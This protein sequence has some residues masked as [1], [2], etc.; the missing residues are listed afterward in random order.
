MEKSRRPLRI[1]EVLFYF[2]L[3]ALYYQGGCIWWVGEVQINEN[4]FHSNLPENQTYLVSWPSSSKLFQ[5]CPAPSPDM[6][7]PLCSLQSFG[8]IQVHRWVLV[9]ITGHVR[10]LDWTYSVNT[11]FTVTKSFCQ[12]YPAGSPGSSNVSRTYPAPVPDMFGL[13]VLT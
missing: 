1:R 4:R 13:L 8:L 6:S 2:V 10:L 3:G 11:I 7:E 9:S 5:T 12:T